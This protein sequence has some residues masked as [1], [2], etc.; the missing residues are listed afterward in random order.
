MGA[1]GRNRARS[2][3]VS[4][5]GN[6]ELN[7]SIEPERVLTE[8]DKAA[9]MYHRLVL[10]V[11]PSGAGKTA[12]L[13]SVA[14]QRAVPCINV[15]L[16]LSKQMLDLTAK[17]EPNVR[18]TLEKLVETGLLEP[19]GTGRGRTYTPDKSRNTS[20]KPDLRPFSRSKWC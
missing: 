16:K 11:A 7:M 5:A 1:P 6:M 20:A 9:E 4:S 12:V 18:A 2:E 3:A 10:V 14:E 15:N 19:H 17:P 13:Q 8:I